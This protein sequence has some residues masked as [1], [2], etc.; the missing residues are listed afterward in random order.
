MKFRYTPVLK[1]LLKT[2]LHYTQMRSLHSIKNFTIEPIEIVRYLD[3]LKWGAVKGKLSSQ[4]F[5]NISFS[6]H[7]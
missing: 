6:V 3:A 5:K 2:D 7:F 4:Y 1:K